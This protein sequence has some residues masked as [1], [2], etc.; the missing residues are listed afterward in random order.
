MH[1]GEIKQERQ[2]TFILQSFFEA[3]SGSSSKLVK[4]GVQIGVQN[5]S[6]FCTTSVLPSPKL[7]I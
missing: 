6:D 4:I 5:G 3:S 7:F 2:S 1:S